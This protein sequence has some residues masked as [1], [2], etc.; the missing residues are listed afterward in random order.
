MLFKSIF[1]LSA[2]CGE[3]VD[4][5]SARLFLFFWILLVIMTENPQNG[6]LKWG[7]IVENP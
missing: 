5:V 3:F 1:L 4:A 7:K 6:L 2:V